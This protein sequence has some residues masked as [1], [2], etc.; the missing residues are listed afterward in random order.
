MQEQAIWPPGSSSPPYSSPRSAVNQLT[1]Q[2]SRMYAWI[3]R[4][5]NSCNKEDPRWLAS[6]GSLLSWITSKLR[7]CMPLLWRGMVAEL[8]KIIPA[9]IL[10]RFEHS[11]S[12]YKLWN[13]ISQEQSVLDVAMPLLWQGMVV[14]LTSTKII[15]ARI[16]PRFERSSSFYKL[17]KLI[18]QEQSVLDVPWENLYMLRWHQDL[19]IEIKI[20]LLN[21]RPRI[22]RIVLPTR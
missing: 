21:V 16:F 2:D 17:W 6:I 9:R 7:S 22:S 18:S 1:V 10:P 15:P 12:F 4:K 14:E 3:Y 11:P 20:T 8:T 19:D 13:L 5:Y